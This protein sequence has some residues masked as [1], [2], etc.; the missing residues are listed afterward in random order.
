MEILSFIKQYITKPRTVGAILPSSKYLAN[1]M[2][3]DIEFKSARYIVEYGSGTGVFTEKIVKGRK[4]NTKILL[5]ESNKK[6]CDLLKDKYKNESDIY[7]INDSAEYIGKYMKKYN[8]PWID[9]IVSGLPFA[10]LPNDLSSN[11]LKETQKHLK[12]EGKFITFQY[13]LLKK[14]FIK[15]YFNKVS[16]KR[17]VRNVPPAY[18][19]CCSF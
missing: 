3:E 9:Y 11:I 8:I 1:K 7:V 19:F 18:V 2:I 4:K 15:K 17:E 16:V 10:S 12:E 5:F 14:D 13:T 6:F